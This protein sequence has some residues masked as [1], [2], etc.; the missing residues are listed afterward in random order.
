[1]DIIA[2]ATHTSLLI[3]SFQLKQFTKLSIITQCF[4]DL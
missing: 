1:V 3:V 2:L 4:H